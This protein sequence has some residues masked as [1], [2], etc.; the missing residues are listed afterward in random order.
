MSNTAKAVLLA[1]A[2]AGPIAA[3]GLIAGF[4]MKAADDTAAQTKIR[5]LI[6][7]TDRNNSERNQ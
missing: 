3:V 6:V 7:A 1:L 2:I 5:V 4:A